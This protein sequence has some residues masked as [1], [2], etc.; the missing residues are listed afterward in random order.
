[1][2]R[3]SSK[4]E[5]WKVVEPALRCS[6]SSK[7]DTASSTIVNAEECFDPK[8]NNAILHALLLPIS[9]IHSSLP[10][11]LLQSLLDFFL[12]LSFVKACAA[13]DS[14]VDVVRHFFKKGPRFKECAGTG[15]YTVKPA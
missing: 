8:F 9:C 2:S 11:L 15:Q 1:M 7:D 6:S 10:N 4:V 3:Q 5:V 14:Y 13:M 12:I